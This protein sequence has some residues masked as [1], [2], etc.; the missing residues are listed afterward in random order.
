[1]VGPCT[2]TPTSLT[3][4]MSS[5]A[6]QSTL[7]S[8]LFNLFS[9][10]IYRLVGKKDILSRELD[11]SSSESEL[12]C[13]PASTCLS[14]YLNYCLVWP[15]L[16]VILVT[17]MTTRETLCSVMSECHI[18]YWRRCVVSCQNATSSI[19]SDVHNFCMKHKAQPLFAV[20][21]LK[22]NN[23]LRK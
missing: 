13:H 23:M 9:L 8:L 4:V 1:M 7:F 10:Q 15:A 19:A 6:F 14:H 21:I 18:F 16:Q 3:A 11:V 17:R 5:L 2:E 20:L 22:E 12:C